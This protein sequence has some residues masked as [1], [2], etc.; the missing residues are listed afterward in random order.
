MATKKRPK[1]ELSRSEKI[2]GQS[3]ASGGYLRMPDSDRSGDAHYKKGWE[4]RLI[5]DDE[6][7]IA[8]LREHLKKA[9]LTPGKPFQKHKRFIQ[10]VYGRAAVESF[11]RWRKAVE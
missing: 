11:Q 3:F 7:A 2:L 4:V 10:P 9:G 6:D 8:Y 5:G 1:P